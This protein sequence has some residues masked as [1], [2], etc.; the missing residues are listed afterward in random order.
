MHKVTWSTQKLKDP[1]ADE[2]EESTIEIAGI[3][4]TIEPPVQ[5]NPAVVENAIK[6]GTL[7]PSTDKPDER[8]AYFDEVFLIG[9]TDEKTVLYARLSPEGSEY[10]ASSVLNFQHR[11]VQLLGAVGID[12]TEFDRSIPPLTDLVI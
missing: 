2:Y 5:F 9:S 7:W 10:Q 3:F 12:A 11:L 1:E 6:Y 4:A 8:V